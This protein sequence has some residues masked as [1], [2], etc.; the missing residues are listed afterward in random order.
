MNTQFITSS[1]VNYLK[2]QDIKNLALVNRYIN[3]VTKE[4]INTYLCLEKNKKTNVDLSTI[5]WYKNQYNMR[6]KN[7]VNVEVLDW[8]Y[9]T[10]TLCYQYITI[11]I[12]L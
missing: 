1:I 3:G 8:W 9:A 6:I 2:V 12:F 11:N 5:S 4:Y 10:V 7:V